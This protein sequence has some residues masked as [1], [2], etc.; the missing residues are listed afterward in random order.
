[1]L[2][3]PSCHPL[4]SA[5]QHRRLFLL[6]CGPIGCVAAGYP[7]SVEIRASRPETGVSIHPLRTEDASGRRTGGVRRP[8]VGLGGTDSVPQRGTSHGGPSQR[9]LSDGPALDA[10]S[11]GTQGL[12]PSALS[13]GD[14]CPWSQPPVDPPGGGTR[15]VSPVSWSTPDV[16]G[17]SRVLGD[18]LDSPSR[19]RRTEIAREGVGWRRVQ[20]GETLHGV[21]DTA[22]APHE[23]E[24]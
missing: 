20:P 23:T 24:G 10:Y 8:V 9:D 22:C 6:A 13:G 15:S 4:L 19:P 2:P 5:L 12:R 14:R 11:R 17:S 21:R 18:P 1:M 16:S 7:V 3:I